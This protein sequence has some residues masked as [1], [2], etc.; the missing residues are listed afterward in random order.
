VIATILLF[1]D[2]DVLG[3]KVVCGA[4]EELT[5]IWQNKPKGRSFVHSPH[6]DRLWSDKSFDSF[7]TASSDDLLV[8]K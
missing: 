6:R 8:A 1:H 5:E 3:S 4:D 2:A 7:L